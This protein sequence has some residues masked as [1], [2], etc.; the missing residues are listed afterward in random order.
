VVAGWVQLFSLMEAERLPG[1]LAPLRG[2]R[3]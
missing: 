3:P 2:A 1:L